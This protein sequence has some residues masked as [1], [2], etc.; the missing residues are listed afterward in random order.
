MYKLTAMKKIIILYILIFLANSSNIDLYA[1][2]TYKSSAGLS[3][4]FGN[5]FTLVGPTYKY[6]TSPKFAITP[7]ILFANGFT[8]ING[9]FQYH[10]KLPNAD[11]LSW[12]AG[13]GASALIAPGGSTFLLRGS[14][15]LDFKLNDIPLAFNLEWRPTLSLNQ[16]GGFSPGRFGIGIRYVIK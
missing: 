3:I 8:S 11:G 5:G 13:G 10:G 6:F 15:G 16:G 2:S 14:T 9:L 4:D 1:Q 7:E 12:I